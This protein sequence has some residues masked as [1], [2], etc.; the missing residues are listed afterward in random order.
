MIL[1]EL[2][3]RNDRTHSLLAKN[4]DLVSMP[5]PRKKDSLSADITK[6]YRLNGVLCEIACYG[7]GN[8]FVCRITRT[9]TKPT[10]SEWT[11][12]YHPPN[13]GGMLW[14]R[15]FDSQ[16]LVTG[17]VQKQLFPESIQLFDMI[18][19][20]IKILPMS[21]TQPKINVAVLDRG[22]LKSLEFNGEQI[23]I[24]Y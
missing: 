2:N 24:D 7:S 23:D 14:I 15:C 17:F 3:F 22:Q 11:D 20:T 8:D 13:D 1:L 6:R 9:D 10:E 19:R 5:L 12:G 16:P 18:E 4:K 21:N